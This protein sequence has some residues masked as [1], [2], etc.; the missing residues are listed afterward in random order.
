MWAIEQESGGSSYLTMHYRRSL[1]ATGAN[2]LGDIAADVGSWILDGALPIGT[3][4]NNGDGTETV[5]ERDTAPVTDAAE[6]RFIRLRISA[7]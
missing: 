3:P 2:F 4:I 7:P 5:T 1:S 6:H